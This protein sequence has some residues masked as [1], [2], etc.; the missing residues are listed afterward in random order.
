MF[1][2]KF[3]PGKNNL[4]D[5]SAEHAVFLACLAVTALSAL[6]YTIIQKVSCFN[7][8]VESN[9]GKFTDGRQGGVWGTLCCKSVLD[10]LCNNTER[11]V[12]PYDDIATV[13]SMDI[14]ECGVDRQLPPEVNAA[15]LA[16]AQFLQGNRK[17]LFLKG[18]H[19]GPLFLA[20]INARRQS[21]Q[22]LSG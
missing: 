20:K 1:T 8:D 7:R 12:L 5:V 14:S 2:G 6:V 15:A 21:P 22:K 13:K 18:D 11:D 17:N 19:V 10:S 16:T 3:D 9:Q 4:A